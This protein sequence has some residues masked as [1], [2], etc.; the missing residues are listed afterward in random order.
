MSIDFPTWWW[1]LVVTLLVLDVIIETFD[2]IF[3]RHD[4]Y[5]GV[6]DHVEPFKG[7]LYYYHPILKV[8]EI[9]NPRNGVYLKTKCDAYLVKRSY[10]TWNV[11]IDEV[12][13]E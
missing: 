9:W 12:D 11:P 6:D 7:C 10:W 1:I 2:L 4:V 8:I 5:I 13:E 3:R